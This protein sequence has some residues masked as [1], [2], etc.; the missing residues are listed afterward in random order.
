M[1]IIVDGAGIELTA[2]QIGTIEKRRKQRERCRYSFKRMLT[3]LG[4][5]ADRE[6]PTSF[7]HRKENW[8]AEIQEYSSGAFNVWMTGPELKDSNGF[9]GGWVY[10]EPKDIETEILSVYAKRLKS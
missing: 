7:G 10:W 9:P 4:F 5:K 1:R 3:H 8:Y 2:K 6:F